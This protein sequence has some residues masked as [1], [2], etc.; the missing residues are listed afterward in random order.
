MA[1]VELFADLVRAGAGAARRGRRRP[2][3]RALQRLPA[4]ARRRARGPAAVVRRTAAARPRPLPR[5]EPGPVARPRTALLR[6]FTSQQRLPEEAGVVMAV[7]ERRLAAGDEAGPPP[8]LAGALDRLIEARPAAVPG[9]G[10]HRPGRR[11]TASSTARSSSTAKPR[12]PPRCATSSNGSTGWHRDPS[13]TVASPGWSRRP[14]PLMGVLNEDGRLATTAHPGTTLEVLTRRYYKIRA[15]DDVRVETLADGS[16]AV[17]AS[18]T[19]GDRTVDVLAVRALVD[20]VATT[21]TTAAAT[22]AAAGDDT[23]AH[24][25]RGRRPLRRPRRRC[26]RWRARSRRSRRAGGVVRR[27]RGR[28]RAR[29]PRHACRRGGGRAGAAGG[30][31]DLHLSPCRTRGRAAVLDARRRGARRVQ[32]RRLRRGRHVPRPAPDDRPPPADVAAVQLRDH[33]PR[34]GRRGVRVR[35]RRP[36]QPRRRASHRRGRGPRPDAGPRRRRAGAGTARA[37]R[38]CSSAAWTASAATWPGAPTPAASSG[39]G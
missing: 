29:L 34:L 35:L 10:Q 28:G 6:M 3:A 13:A 24:P 20:G 7:L 11:A 33:P 27:R 17:R 36:H 21:L 8:A 4:F 25:H 15:L 30:G 18:Y 12:S 23:A 22:L 31:A 26:R 32:R 19:R 16:E 14:L 2:A 5:D 9:P 38:R 39:T 1:L 37:W